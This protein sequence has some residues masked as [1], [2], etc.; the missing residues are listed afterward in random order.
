MDRTL[1]N[2]G[3]YASFD[4]YHIVLEVDWSPPI[5]LT[6]DAYQSLLAYVDS[7]PKHV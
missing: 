3:V 6:P 4:G 1:L 2:D 7:L 5:Y